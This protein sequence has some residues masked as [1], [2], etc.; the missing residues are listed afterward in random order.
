MREDEGSGGDQ[1]ERHHEPT[2]ID[3]G[4]HLQC[5]SAPFQVGGEGQQADREDGK[6]R[7]KRERSSIPSA[8]RV[9][10]STFTDG[11][12][13]RGDGLHDGEHRDDQQHEPSQAVRR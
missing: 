1:R 7:E 8:D 10:E 6:E 4:H 9:L 12:Q 5:G 13:A 11:A 3:A 2:V